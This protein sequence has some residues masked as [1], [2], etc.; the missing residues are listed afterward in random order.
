MSIKYLE[1]YENTPWAVYIYHDFINVEDMSEKHKKAV[2]I[3]GKNSGS[4]G[5][6]MGKRDI[7][8]YF[9]TEEEAK[10]VHERLIEAGFDPVISWC[11]A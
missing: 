3:A 5:C 2:E 4:S 11:E 7:Q 10:E 1:Q 8:F 6:G 9:E